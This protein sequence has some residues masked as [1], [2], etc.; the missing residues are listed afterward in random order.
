MHR[1]VCFVS[2]VLYTRAFLAKL[3]STCVSSLFLLFFLCVCVCI[4]ACSSDSN[5]VVESV[6]EMA[7]TAVW[8]AVNS[9][10]E[11]CDQPV[12]HSGR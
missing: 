8:K 3:M 1:S 6:D 10:A 9:S 7:K 2:T 11:S 4:L 12:M 5:P